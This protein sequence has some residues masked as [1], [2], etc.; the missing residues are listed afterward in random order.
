MISYIRAGDY[1]LYSFV[2][3]FIGDHKSDIK[4]TITSGTNIPIWQVDHYFQAFQDPYELN[5]MS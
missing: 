4:V 5:N 3:G 2:H 1:N